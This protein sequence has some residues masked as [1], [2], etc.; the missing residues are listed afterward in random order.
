MDTVQPIRDIRKIE[1]VK[2]VLLGSANG[3]RNHLLFVLGINSGLRISDLLNLSVGDVVNDQGNIKAAITLR[4]QKTGKEKSFPLNINAVKAISLHIKTIPQNDLI[5]PLFA[6]RKGNK[7]ISRV[8]A[9]EIL[10]RAAEDVGITEATGTHSLRKT[11]GYHAFKAGIGIERL[12]TILNHSSP[13]I[14]LRYIGIT[15]D[16]INDVYLK[17]NL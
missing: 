8:Q 5:A 1:A 4:E 3:T 17:L 7:P 11:F 14:T 13:A 9:W 2:K 15:Q 12:Q 10:N 6:S 16:D